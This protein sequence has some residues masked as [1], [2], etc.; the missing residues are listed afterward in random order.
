LVNELLLML[1]YGTPLHFFIIHQV[2]YGKCHNITG[3]TDI[4]FSM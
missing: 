2:K 3:L 4:N 1:L